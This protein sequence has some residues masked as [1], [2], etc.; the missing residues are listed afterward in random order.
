MKTCFPVLKYVNIPNLLTSLGLCFGVASLYFLSERNLR[1]LLMC[2]FFAAFI[3]LIDGFAASKLNQQSRF[4]VYVDSLADFSI[5]CILPAAT[6]YLFIGHHIWLLCA[7]AFYC[8]C[9]M[10]RL[11]NFNVLSTEKQ[12]HLTGL[13]VPGAM[14][15]STMAL[16]GV[17][18]HGLPV[19]FSVAVFLLAGGFMVSAVRLKKYGL[20]QKFV[21]LIWL[22]FVV[23]MY[24]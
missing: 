9:G 2:L 4:G 20:T 13:P 11:A 23:F 7:I 12:T 8:V 22:G 14:L 19:W 16:W 6:A 1:G 15:F 24:I 5:C 3:D 21:W 10:W 17:V 18:Q